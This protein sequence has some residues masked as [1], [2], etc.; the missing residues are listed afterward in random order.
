MRLTQ[1]P[2]GL[3]KQCPFGSR[4]LTYKQGLD[5]M[6]MSNPHKTFDAGGFHE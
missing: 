3:R 2:T 4:L 6:A 5:T 1:K